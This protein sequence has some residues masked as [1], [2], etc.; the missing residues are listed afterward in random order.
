MRQVPRSHE[1]AQTSGES[2]FA[3]P[4]TR[5]PLIER[6]GELRGHG[7]VY[8]VSDG[9]PDFLA[10]STDEQIQTDYSPSRRGRNRRA[11]LAHSQMVYE[12]EHTYFARA[13]QSAGRHLDVLDVGCGSNKFELDA[14]GL[15]KPT[16]STLAQYSR[17][18]VG[19]DPTWAMLKAATRPGSGLHRLANAR[20]VRGIGEALPFANETFDV[21]LFKSSL[22]HCRDGRAALAEARRVLRPSGH[23]LIIIQNFASWQ[24]RLLA[25][26]FPERYAEH[27]RQDAINHPSPFTRPHLE[28]ILSDLGFTIAGLTEL[29]YMRLSRYALG[30]VEDALLYVPHRLGGEAGLVRTVRRVDAT[31][32]SIAPGLGTTMVCW[33]SASAGDAST[34]HG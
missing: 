33:A 6:E 3:C 21:V 26:C 22:D 32:Q 23:V 13:A 14:N 27:R 11:G 7:S 19:L 29:G 9:I 34:A 17:T 30:W 10:S 8:P 28:R 5:L 24:R 4:T 25:L 1:S 15:L 18:Y 20:L 16:L 12:L 31:L 2:F